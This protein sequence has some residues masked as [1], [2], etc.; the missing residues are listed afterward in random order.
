VDTKGFQT[1][2]QASEPAH[3]NYKYAKALE[4]LLGLEENQPRRSVYL[5]VPE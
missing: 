5:S 3:K 2:Q 4:P 1:L